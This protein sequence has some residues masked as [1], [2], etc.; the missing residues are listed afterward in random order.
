MPF[1]TVSAWSYVGLAMRKLVISGLGRRIHP[2]MSA[3]DCIDR[4]R[5]TDRQ[6]VFVGER[7]RPRNRVIPLQKKH[8]FHM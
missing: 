4:D 5:E 7:E 3:A 6:S 8:E 2:G 1:G